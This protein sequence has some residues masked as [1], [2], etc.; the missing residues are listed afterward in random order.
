M[1]VW[2]HLQDV[3]DGVDQAKHESSEAELQASMQVAADARQLIMETVIYL[4]VRLMV[5][6]RTDATSVASS[7]TRIHSAQH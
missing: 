2:V 6:L 7:E 5:Q 3:S 4:Q 1:C